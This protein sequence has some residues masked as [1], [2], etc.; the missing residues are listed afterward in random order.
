MNVHVI[1]DFLK[2]RKYLYIL[3]NLHCITPFRDT[4]LAELKLLDKGL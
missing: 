1:L 2:H 3:S 4:F